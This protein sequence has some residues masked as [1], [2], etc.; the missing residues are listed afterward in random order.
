[1]MDF[2]QSFIFPD[3]DTPLSYIFHSHELY[4]LFRKKILFRIEIPLDNPYE[5]T[6]PNG[7]LIYGPPCN[8]K[9]FLARHFAQEAKLPYIII[10]RYNLLDDRSNH[11]D[12]GF[13]ELMSVAQKVAP[14]VIILENVETIVPNRKDLR[15][16]GESVNVMSILSLIRGCGEKG[17]YIFATTSRP[18]EVDPQ[19]GMNGYLNDLFYTPF[20]DLKQRVLILKQLIDNKPHNKGIH[21]EKIAAY[22]ENFTIGDLVSFIEEVA[23]ESAI[24]NTPISED[25]ATS[26]LEKFRSSQSSL[27]KK[28]YD[29]LNL[30]LENNKTSIK[31]NIGFK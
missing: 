10:N 27:D 18:T 15:N 20:P 1:M 29:E 6:P 31:K 19:L 12:Y 11:T 14:C 8:G 22:C 7:L 4:D 13:S 5:I 28:N 30:L 26:T 2:K 24:L 16:N 9:T 17:I 23:I 25:I 21:L 3:N